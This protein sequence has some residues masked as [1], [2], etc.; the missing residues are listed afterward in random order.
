MV[1]VYYILA[2]FVHTFMKIGENILVGNDYYWFLISMYKRTF[3]FLLTFKGV[4]LTD[5]RETTAAI[6]ECPTLASAIFNSL[7]AFMPC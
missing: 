7:S 6:F 1:G 4:Q 2:I 3:S 5:Y